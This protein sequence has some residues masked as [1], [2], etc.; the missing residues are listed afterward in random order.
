MWGRVLHMWPY[1]KPSGWMNFADTS[2]SHAMSVVSMRCSVESR[3]IYTV[4][5]F[6]C[7]V[8]AVVREQG[9]PCQTCTTRPITHPTNTHQFT[10]PQCATL[11][12]TT[13][14]YK[15]K[16]GTSHCTTPLRVNTN[17]HTPTRLHTDTLTTSLKREFAIRPQGL[18]I[19]E[20]LETNGEQSATSSSLEYTVPSNWFCV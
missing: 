17:I 16:H 3:V 10:T 18:R 8:C 6:V 13:P 11:R 14:F 12:H 9:C 5:P 7:L 20:P 15:V 1:L 19:L 2:D 4:P